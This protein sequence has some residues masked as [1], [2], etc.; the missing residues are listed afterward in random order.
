MESTAK[1]GLNRTLVLPA[2]ATLLV[3]GTLFVLGRLFGSLVVVAS[4]IHWLLLFA[5]IAG[6]RTQ[7]LDPQPGSTLPLRRVF[8]ALLFLIVTFIGVALANGFAFVAPASTGDLLGLGA[9]M[10]AA[11][12]GSVVVARFFQS[13]Q[14]EA[15][16][17]ELGLVKIARIGTWLSLFGAASVFAAHFEMP[18]FELQVRILLVVVPVLLAIEL[19]FRG[20]FALVAP[21]PTGAAFGADL[22]IARVFGSSYNPIQSAFNS[23]EDTFGV[24]V[25]SSWALGFLRRVSFP[26]LVGLGFGRGRKFL[27]RRG[28]RCHPPTRP[29]PILRYKGTG[30]REGLG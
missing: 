27:R 17:D 6:A 22:F 2:V 13:P 12:V 30:G 18:A 24:D 11:A 8:V 15:I 3:S 19:L 14:S 10:L 9:L 29:C 21:P 5:L 16:G 4:S 1:F 7:V 28:L 25:R 26:L 20:V 23:V